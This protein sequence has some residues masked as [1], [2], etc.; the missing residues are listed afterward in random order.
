MSMGIL[1]RLIER[2]TVEE[3]LPLEIGLQRVT[4]E[5]EGIVGTAKGEYYM[6][7]W[8][9]AIRPEVT[10]EKVGTF[11]R[12][13]L[14]PYFVQEAVFVHTFSRNKLTGRTHHVLD[15]T[16]KKPQ[17]GL[18]RDRVVIEYDTR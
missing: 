3:T 14:H 1:H 12:Y 17:H 13:R 11:V 9:A 5:M 6:D 15:I 10:P 16:P 7:N 2:R 4:R 18:P 8:C